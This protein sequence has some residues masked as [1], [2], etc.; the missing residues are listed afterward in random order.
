M[1]SH[2]PVSYT[3]LDVYKRQHGNSGHI[4]T[5][6]GGMGLVNDDGEPLA[7]QSLHAVH[8]I[9]ELLYGGSDDLRVAVE[10]NRQIGGVTFIVHHTDQ[11]LSLIHI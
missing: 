1:T 9:R 7:F 4:L 2:H 8:D 11:P 3:H 6:G 5:C 10:G